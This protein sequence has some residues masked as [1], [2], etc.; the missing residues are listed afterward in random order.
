MYTGCELCCSRDAGDQ[1]GTLHSFR[2][3][4]TSARVIASI[5]SDPLSSCLFSLYKFYYSVYW[6]WIVWFADAALLL[7]PCLERPAYFPDVPP[8]VALIIEI[9]VLLILLVSFLITMHFQDKRQLLREAVYPYIFAIVFLVNTEKIPFE[10]SC[11][12]SS[13]RLLI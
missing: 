13:S 11:R 10:I 1:C 3:R 2:S 5:E 12:L 8:W 4:Q 6:Y 9:I 7:L